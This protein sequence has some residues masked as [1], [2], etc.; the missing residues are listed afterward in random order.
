[1]STHRL[2][3]WVDGRRMGTLAY[4]DDTGRFAFDYAPEWVAS[5]S[6]FPLSPA[7]P[8]RAPKDVS[9]EHHSVSVR[10]FFENLL[11]EGKA[12]DDAVFAHRLAKANLYG[13]LLV[14]G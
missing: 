11:P 10:R 1:M 13:L 14:L 5:R 3:A 6:A 9:D 2:A 7:L 4:H 8:L 12:L